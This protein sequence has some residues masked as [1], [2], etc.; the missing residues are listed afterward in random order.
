LHRV[1]FAKPQNNNHRIPVIAASHAAA[2]TRQHAR[3]ST[4]KKKKNDKNKKLCHEAAIKLKFHGTDTDNV[5]KSP[6]GGAVR[7][8]GDQ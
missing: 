1:D 2:R 7:H 8:C 4:K 6:E 5:K 3:S